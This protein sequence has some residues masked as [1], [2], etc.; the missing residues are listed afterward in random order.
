MSRAGVP[1]ALPALRHRPARG[2]VAALGLLAGVQFL[3]YLLLWFQF[4]ATAGLAKAP[5]SSQTLVSAGWY[6]AGSGYARTV[7]KWSSVQHM[8]NAPLTRHWFL[9]IGLGLAGAGYVGTVVL[10]RRRPMKIAPVTIALAT[11]LI[12]LP[13]LLLPQMLSGDLW[14]YV[15][16]GRVAVLHGGN[17][18]VDLPA[19][20]SHDP[21]LGRMYWKTT[22]SIYGPGWVSVC[23]L[24]T[25]LAQCFGGTP[26]IYLVAFKGF[27]FA[28]HLVNTL[29]VR[30]LAGILQPGRQTMAAVLYALNPLCLFEFAG[31]GH[32]DCFM[33]TLLLLGMASA[34]ANR[35]TSAVGWITAAGLTKLPGLLSLPAYALWISRQAKDSRA[36]WSTLARQV[37]IA[38]VVA[39]ALYAP[40]WHGLATFRGTANAPN[41]R[42]LW[43]SLAAHAADHLERR[44]ST[45]GHVVPWWKGDPA[46]GSTAAR[47]RSAV[48]LTS[49]ACFLA[50]FV[51]LTLGR[52][53]RFDEWL[54]RII[55][56][57][58]AYL[59]FAAFQFNPWY[60]TWLVPVAALTLR[61][62]FPILAATTC[63]SFYLPSASKNADALY[64]L[65]LLCVLGIQLLTVFRVSTPRE[66]KC[67]ESAS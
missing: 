7:Q 33:L 57:Y 23:I 67:A 45:T 10:L 35:S 2:V 14:G 26:W 48:R 32:N 63:L 42:L 21:F 61:S 34:A 54:G 50:C 22:P 27:V 13:L 9:A 29:L 51:P 15:M 28:A 44:L 24:L 3:G 58:L 55:C 31:S 11:V 18:I 5:V 30:R 41:V 12:A 8:L 60:A 25:Y 36:R 40:F 6:D 59:L 66:L 37:A 52:I 20:Y 1:E 46:P 38:A 16:Y 39:V 4:H 43:H 56:I 19:A 65:P 53:R 47:V 64:L 62:T 49:V 17:P